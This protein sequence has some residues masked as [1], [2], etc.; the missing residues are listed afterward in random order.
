MSEKNYK[1]LLSTIISCIEIGL[2]VYALTLNNGGIALWVDEK[3][4]KEIFHEDMLRRVQK[5]YG[6][7]I[8]DIENKECLAAAYYLTKSGGIKNIASITNFFGTVDQ[9]EQEGKVHYPEYFGELE[10]PTTS[11]WGNVT[12]TIPIDNGIMLVKTYK[13]SGLAIHKDIIEAYLSTPVE[14]VGLKDDAYL[15]Y[16][17]ESSCAV[18][19]YELAMFNSKVLD[20]IISMDSLKATLKENFSLYVKGQSLDFENVYYTKPSGVFLQQQID[21][22]INTI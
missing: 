1:S 7:Y 13:Q 4:A 17:I 19:L 15:F 10:P 12:E 16:D 8:F 11:V 3:L 22:H 18:P 21:L 14:E 9:M 5:A 2:N 6:K 20:V